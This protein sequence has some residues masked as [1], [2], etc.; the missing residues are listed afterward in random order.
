MHPIP[1]SITAARV[2]SLCADRDWRLLN[3]EEI[4]AEGAFLQRANDILTTW[5]IPEECQNI[6]DK[7]HERAIVHEY[8]QLL[9][10]AVGQRNTPVWERAL[11]EIWNYITPLIRKILR[12]DDLAHD[13]AMDVLLTVCEKRDQVRDPGCFLSWAGVIARRA[14][15]RA[16]QRAGREAPVSALTLGDDEANW[17]EEGDGEAYLD[18]L[19]LERGGPAQPELNGSLRAAELEA[20]I[21]EC[22]RRM[23]HGAA[24]FI[25]LALHELPV[26][27]IAR[28]LG[29][30]VNAVYVIFHRARKRLQ[31]CGP[32]LADLG[33]ALEA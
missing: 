28:Q 15:V 29:V 10:A 1:T 13:V 26:S 23:R 31:R 30:K 4:W 14:A 33:V 20:R 9:H 32:L 7:L 11:I 12:D 19:R 27:E 5:L 24:V 25:G 16:S 18:K 8:S 17:D 22:L 2:R 6:I 3:F 21:R